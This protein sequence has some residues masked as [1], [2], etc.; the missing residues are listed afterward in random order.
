MSCT[1]FFYLKSLF[2]LKNLGALSKQVVKKVKCAQTKSKR[3]NALNHTNL[4]TKRYDR[5]LISYLVKVSFKFLTQIN[6]YYVIKL[7]FFNLIDL[8]FSYLN[9]FVNQTHF[10]V[11]C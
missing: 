6:N 11:S 9:F 5:A 1:L 2:K 4:P 7:Y 10:V 8:F 3:R